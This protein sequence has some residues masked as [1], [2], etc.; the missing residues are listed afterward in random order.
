VLAGQKLLMVT[1]AIG[2]PGADN[3]TAYVCRNVLEL[4]S[5]PCAA[6]SGARAS[7]TA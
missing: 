5:F 4:H 1:A 6:T 2:A 3:G 7:A